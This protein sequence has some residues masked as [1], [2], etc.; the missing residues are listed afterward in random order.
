MDVPVESEASLGKDP[1]ETGYAFSASLISGLSILVDSII[2]L[3]SGI[4]SYAIIVGVTASNI[5][6]YLSAIFFIFIISFVLFHFA[7]LYQFEAI[8]HPNN[9]WDKL[10]VAFAISFFLLLAIAF[11]LKVSATYSRI[12]M[13]AFAMTAGSSIIVAR[14]CLYMLFKRLLDL[15]IFVRNVVILGGGDKAQRLL[16]HIIQNGPG[17]VSVVGIFDIKASL[18][19]EKISDYPILGGLN[20]LEAFVRARKVDDVIIA[21]PFSTG[22]ELVSIVGKIRQL[23]VNIYYSS[24]LI[25]HQL[26]FHPAPSHYQ[27]LPIVEIVDKP[28]SDWNIAL[29]LI[30]D[31]VLTIFILILFAPVML[32][33][34]VAIKLES[35]GPIL[36]RQKRLGFNNR[37]FE[38]YKFRSM[39][40]TGR[41]EKVTLQAT[42]NDQ[43]VT[44][45]G[46]IIRRLSFDE[47]PQLFNVLN[48][49]MSLVGPRPHAIDHNQLYSKKIG[50]YFARHRVKPGI[51]GWAQING[52]RG[53]T[54]DLK[55]MEARV[56]CDIYYADNWSLIFDLRILFVTIFI[57]ITGKNAY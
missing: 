41:A 38:V 27:N 46:K 51:T 33:V 40:H 31:I 25:G 30:E 22:D 3:S 18:S 11:S 1:K 34:A 49:T 28:I 50:G 32:L 48:G 47:L 43:R 15:G 8:M 21:L 53:Q 37:V 26:T 55:K 36:F 16:D 17:F 23:P 42:Q 9:Y 4:A 13:S 54:E 57:C 5:E 14:L 20:E 39:R 7:G 19:G 56:D 52:L 6:L 29:K 45:V 12:W 10:I 44:R 2:I 35:P 24:D